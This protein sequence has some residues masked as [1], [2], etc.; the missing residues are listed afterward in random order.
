MYYLDSAF[1]HIS[2]PN[3]N[4]RFRFY[5]FHYVYQQKTK[6]NSKLALLY[7][8]SML[9]MAQKSVS[10]QQYVSNFAE[11]NYAKGDAYFNLE[12]I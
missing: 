7:A 3:L 6:G 9:I 2:K 1:V 5:G 12:S 8:D 10:K 11:A 4:D